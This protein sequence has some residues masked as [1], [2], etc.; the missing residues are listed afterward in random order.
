MTRLPARRG[1]VVEDADEPGE[2]PLRIDVLFPVAAHEEVAAG[3]QPEPR[4]DVR[5]G[6]LRHVVVEHLAHR[7]AG[8]DHPVRGN[9]FAQQV[10]PRDRAVGQVDVGD[11]IDDA[12]V[13]LLR[14]AHVEAAVAGFHVKH[15]HAPALRGNGGEAGI[16]VAEDEHGV[17]L[18]SARALSTAMMTCPIVS[19]AVC[20]GRGQVAVGRAELEVFEEHLVQLVVVVLARVD[21][22][23]V[24][25]PV[26]RRH[27]ARQADDLGPR[28]D[29]GHHLEP[30]HGA[31][32]WDGYRGGR[33]RGSRT[34]RTA[35]SSRVAPTFSM[36]CVVP[37]GM[38]TT[39]KSVPDTRC[40]V[41]APPSMGRKRITAS[42]S[43]TQNF[44]TLRS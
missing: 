22:H 33:G 23:V 14:H 38:S 40:A 41:T 12:A 3:L 1:E 29:N 2:V 19:A 32:R 15:G 31:P 28:A 30:S 10:L 39:L 13:D 37:G 42:P 34:P 36:L 26:E 25:V 9:P 21:Q 17:G 43:S 35:R 16:R 11:V 44:S 8:R 24:R 6:D 18:T 27:H 5:P 7:A 4:Q 20:A